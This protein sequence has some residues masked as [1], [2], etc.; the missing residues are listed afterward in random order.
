MIKLQLLALFTFLFAMTNVFGQEMNCGTE[1]T[2]DP[3]FDIL[4]FQAFKKKMQKQAGT[5]STIYV[6]IKAHVVRTSAGSGGLSDTQL[7]EA[8]DRLNEIYTPSGIHFFLCDGINYIHS[9]VIFDYDANTESAYIYQYYEVDALNIYFFNSVISTSGNSVCGFAHLPWGSN[10]LDDYVA[11]KNSCAVNGSTLSHEIG[12]FFGLYHTHH[13][14]IG[15]E[16]VNGSNCASTGDLCCDTPADPTLSSSLVSTSCVYTG[17]AT[18]ANGDLY[19]P[20]PTNLMSYSRKS[21][22][23]FLSNEQFTRVLYYQGTARDYLTC[24]STDDFSVSDFT[25][26]STSLTAGASYDVAINQHYTGAWLTSSIDPVKINFYLSSDTL[27]SSNDFVVLQDSSSLGS[28]APVDSLLATITIPENVPTGNY[29]LIAW[30]DASESF[31]EGDET[32]NLSYIEVTVKNDNEHLFISTPIIYPNPVVDILTYETNY[33]DLEQIEVLN[34][35]GQLM[36]VDTKFDGSLDLSN[37]S[38]GTYVIRFV[39]LSKEASVFHIVKE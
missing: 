23:D 30:S 16:L 20:D 21:C 5:K 31:V 3:T 32:N 26:D 28:D 27:V 18:D 2:P 39:H 37:L 4:K 7:I 11:M 15:N 13:T 17:T 9:S 34:N 33:E 36:V 8:I 12:H 24:T 38:R 1:E 19:V 22:R 6:P 10:Q 25:S 35:I 14:S 29:Q